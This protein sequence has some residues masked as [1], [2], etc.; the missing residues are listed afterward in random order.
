[1]MLMKAIVRPDKVDA[2]KDALG[3]HRGRRHDRDRGARA[4]QAE[5]TH[6][7]L[8]RPG[9]SGEPAAR[10]WRSK[11]SSPIIGGRGRRAAI[12]RPRAP[13]KSATAAVFVMPVDRATGSAQ[14][15][16]KC[17]K[18]GMSW[19]RRLREERDLLVSTRRRAMGSARS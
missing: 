12:I 16:A 15:S 9:I 10:R 6:R 14:E 3:A 7:D 19:R 17:S 2:V 4:R 11:S 18:A 8:S 1:M 5:G 13:A